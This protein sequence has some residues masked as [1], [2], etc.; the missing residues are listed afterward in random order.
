MKPQLK[1]ER[2][3]QPFQ[4]KKTPKSQWMDCHFCSYSTPNQ[5]YQKNEIDLTALPLPTKENFKIAID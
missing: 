3:T 2:I 4:T 1:K 5:R